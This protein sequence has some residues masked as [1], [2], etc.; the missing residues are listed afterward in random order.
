MKR[1]TLFARLSV[2]AV[3]IAVGASA[4]L[5]GTAGADH[6]A[7]GATLSL[8]SWG[9]A[10]QLRFRCEN[11]WRQYERSRG[12]RDGERAGWNAGY[13][14]GYH[15]HAH[16]CVCTINLACES[17][18]YQRG[19]KDGFECAYER[20]YIAGK[21]ARERERCNHSPFARPVQP[22]IHPRPID[23]GPPVHIQPV[24]PDVRFNIRF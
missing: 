6:N 23:H 16:N 17:I 22:I 12:E 2:S 21:I 4:G 10:Q 3:L 19:F 1:S 24:R 5:A 9:P 13:H 8:N 15:C 11:D 18:P 20:G 14:D 7:P